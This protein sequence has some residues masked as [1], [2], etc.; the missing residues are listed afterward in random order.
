MRYRVGVSEDISALFDPSQ[1]GRGG[2]VVAMLLG[3]GLVG[4]SSW[5]LLSARGGLWSFGMFGGLAM[6][7]SGYMG[8][9]W[10]TR[11]ARKRRIGMSVTDLRAAVQ[12][13]ELGF[14]ICTRCMILMPRNYT[15][16]C[17]EC[18]SSVGTVEVTNEA[19]RRTAL[20]AIGT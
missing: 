13:H 19:E 20:V 11:A 12:A 1:M 18:T 14:W 3:M 6:I 8:F 7:G 15:A 4:V 17:L 16:D 5:Q 9:N 10:G 2:G